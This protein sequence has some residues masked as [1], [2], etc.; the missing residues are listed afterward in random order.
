MRSLM[1]LM[2]MNVLEHYI[3]TTFK[4]SCFLKSQLYHIPTCLRLCLFL[5]PVYRLCYNTETQL[6]INQIEVQILRSGYLYSLVPTWDICGI[7]FLY[8]QSVY[9]CFVPRFFKTVDTW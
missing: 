8:R 5:F 3:I 1:L 7:S 2:D 4:N 6:A 9:V